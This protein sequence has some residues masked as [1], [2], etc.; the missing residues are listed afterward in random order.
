[1]RVCV[2]NILLCI[3]MLAL[4]GYTASQ[5]I[6]GNKLVFGLL[7]STIY[8]GILIPICTIILLILAFIGIRKDEQLV[9]DSDRLR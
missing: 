7:G 6:L 9:K 4:Q 5:N 1:M 8:I 3:T 2:L